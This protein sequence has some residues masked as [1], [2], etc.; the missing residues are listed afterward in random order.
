MTF[1]LNV[2]LARENNTNLGAGT[3]LRDLA[4]YFTVRTHSVHH[5]DT[6]ITVV[7]EIERKGNTLVTANSL[8]HLAALWG[9]DC[10]ATWNFSTCKGAL[11]GPRADKWGTFNPEYFLLLDGRRMSDGVKVAA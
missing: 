10:I 8:Y 5:S 2:G 9:Q 4:G 6:E 11:I 1:L 3:V 7:V